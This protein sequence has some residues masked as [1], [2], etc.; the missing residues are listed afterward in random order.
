MGLACGQDPELVLNICR[1]VRAAVKIPFFAKLTP[2]VTN[3]LDIARAAKEGGMEFFNI[4]IQNSIQIIH[5]CECVMVDAAHEGIH[6]GAIKLCAIVNTRIAL[7]CHNVM[8]ENLG[9][10]SF[11]KWVYYQILARR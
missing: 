11:I 2:N 7:H 9:I 10:I 5:R 1:W 6:Y 4:F 3:I 8:N